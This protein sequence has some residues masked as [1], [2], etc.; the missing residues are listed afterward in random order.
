M[1]PHLSK[2]ILIKFLFQRT[3]QKSDYKPRK[4]AES[5]LQDQVMSSWV[6]DC[7][8]KA[9]TRPVGNRF[10][11]SAIVDFYPITFQ[12]GDQLNANGNEYLSYTFVPRRKKVIFHRVLFIFNVE[13]FFFLLLCSVL[14]FCCCLKKRGCGVFVFFSACFF[15]WLHSWVVF[16]CGVF[17]FILFFEL[18]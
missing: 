4:R 12:K 13:V 9:T 3:S 14:R 17:I 5:R 10:E 15:G 11:M 1:W 8:M 6:T 2:T 16:L 18:L 7:I